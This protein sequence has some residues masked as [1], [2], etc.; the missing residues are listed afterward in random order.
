MRG[1]NKHGA[2]PC[3][4]RSTLYIKIPFW[5][6]DGAVP[7]CRYTAVCRVA[8]PPW[9][10]RAQGRAWRRGASTP[11]FPPRRAVFD[12][13]MNTKYP[14]PRALEGGRCYLRAGRARALKVP[15]VNRLEKGKGVT[16]P[17]FVIS[18]GSI[19]APASGSSQVQ[20]SRVPA[21]RR[22]ANLSRKSKKAVG[23][24]GEGR[25]R[26]LQLAGQLV[27]V[28]AVNAAMWGTQLDRASVYKCRAGTPR[29]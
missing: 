14:F 27:A 26:A 11:N 15:V 1:W 2:T 28:I 6:D 22:R 16:P 4:G 21:P 23:R 19:Q 24:G 10:C 29:R 13:A 9:A 20:R 25:G 7:R 5:P 8:S 12:E 3:A 17:P 18:P